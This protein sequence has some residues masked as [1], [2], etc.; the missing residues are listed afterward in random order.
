MNGK[1]WPQNFSFAVIALALSTLAACSFTSLAYNSAPWFIENRIDDYFS[2]SRTQH[3]QVEADIDQLLLWHRR[4]ELPQYVA[5]L[6]EFSGQFSD[7]LSREELR[8]LLEQ[9]KQA[10]IRFAEQS[11]GPASQ[12]LNNISSKQ[13]DYFDQQVKERIAENR[14]ILELSAEERDQED[15]EKLRDILE[16]WFGTFDKQQRE[17][18]RIISDALPDNRAHWISKRER[19]HREFLQLLRQ[20][21]DDSAI[22][23][24]LRR[25]YVEENFSDDAE[26]AMSLEARAHWQSALLE[27]DKLLNQEQRQRGI[28]K[29]RGYRDD[30]LVLSRQEATLVNNFDR[31]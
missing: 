31:R 10:R 3:K 17:Q 22:E 9:L 14:E 28:K 27:I 21:R 30:F 18:L 8:W 1:R 4:N 15:Y 26:R 7:G 11:I 6:D 5:V 25:R 23:N 13:I 12:F 20:S 16:D 2:L 24:A 29:L 19:Q